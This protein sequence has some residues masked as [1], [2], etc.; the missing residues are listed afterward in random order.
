MTLRFPY[1]KYDGKWVADVC[2]IYIDKIRRLMFIYEKEAA[3]DTDILKLEI[4][5][6]N[7]TVGQHE[8]FLRR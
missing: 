8:C 6:Y 1:L 5:Y 2:A 4:W 7:K 3:N